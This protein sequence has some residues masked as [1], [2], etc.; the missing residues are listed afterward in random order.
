VAAATEAAAA[1]DF[2]TWDVITLTLDKTT[3]EGD[4]IKLFF[5]K[6]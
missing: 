3:R 5:P 6:A 2:F 4:E 1:T